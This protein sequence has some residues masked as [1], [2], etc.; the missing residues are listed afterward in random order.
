MNAYS[1]AIEWWLERYQPEPDLLS[2]TIQFWLDRYFK[3]LPQ[4]DLLREDQMHDYQEYLAD[5]IDKLAGQSEIPGY[6]LAVPMSMGKTVS[7]LTA[8]AR[9]LKRFPLAR[10]LIVAPLEVVKNTWPDEIEKWEHLR[11]LQHTVVIGDE[12]QRIEALKRDVEITLINRENLQWLWGYVGERHG[13]RWNFLIYDESSRLKGFTQRTP[14]K[15]YKDGKKIKTR[16]NLT[17]F[18][19]LVHARPKFEAVVELTGTPAGNGVIDLGGQMRI[20]DEGERLGVTKTQFHERYF[21]VNAYSRQIKPKKGAK[22]KIMAQV[23]DLMLGLRAEDY[24]HLPPINV[25]PKFVT[26]SHKS[27]KE[28]DQFRR[29]AVSVEYDVEAVNKG[30]LVNKLLQ[31]ANGGLYR[32]DPD[33]PKAA[34]ETLIVHDQKLLALESIMEEAAGNNVLVGYSFKFD[35]MRI[36]KKFPKAVFYDEDPNFIKRWNRGEIQMGVAHPASI[37]H[38][39]NLQKGGH[40][41]VWYGL[42]WSREL[43]DQFNRRLA[44]QG[45]NAERVFVY[46]ILAK[47]T[48]DEIQY[49]ALMAKGEEQDWVMDQVRVNLRA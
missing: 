48:Y 11:H 23:K 41:Q 25:I 10:F 49:A 21:D 44:R 4:D 28:Y 14:G 5:T 2:V 16:R 36:K 7:V 46:P 34:R 24:I 31:F 8:I 6:L 15:K 3:T 33:D 38:G 9:I 43:W 1:T 13:W 30:V 39:T 22:E 20:I 45:Q 18:G 40:I 29:D 37:G 35:A 12:T 42:C 27:R 47:N 32:K 19:V 17:E 26:L